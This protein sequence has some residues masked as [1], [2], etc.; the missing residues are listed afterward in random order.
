MEEIKTEYC[1]TQCGKFTAYKPEFRT[2]DVHVW[3]QIPT[4]KH[5]KGVPA[6]KQFGGILSTIHLFGHA[7]ASALMWWWAATAEAAGEKVDVR[8]VEYEVAYD[9]KAKIIEKN[10]D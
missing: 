10:D 4:S 8:L 6:P 9:I 2:E 1:P 7:Q 5:P 3:M